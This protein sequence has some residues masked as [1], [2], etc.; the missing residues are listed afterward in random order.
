MFNKS[1]LIKGD[2][3]LS[4]EPQK[5]V[6]KP[7][8]DFFYHQGNHGDDGRLT[9]NFVGNSPWNQEYQF[10]CKNADGKES[11]K[12][13][14][15]GPIVLYNWHKPVIKIKPE[16]ED[17]PCEDGDSLV[18]YARNAGTNNWYDLTKQPKEKVQTNGGEAL[19]G[20]NE[21]F[22]RDFRDLP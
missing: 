13:K 2:D 15:Y 12:T 18:I 22:F 9:F 4:N 1:F 10:S 16:P 19:A 17:K 6:K 14:V 3:V 8:I 11:T 5:T 20:K 7:V 21:G